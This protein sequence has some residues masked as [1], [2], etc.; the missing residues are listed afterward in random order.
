MEAREW[1]AR[2]SKD[3]EACSLKATRFHYTP[4]AVGENSAN[5][6][7]GIMTVSSSNTHRFNFVARLFAV[8]PGLLMLIVFFLPAPANASAPNK[9]PPSYTSIAA[10]PGGGFWIQIDDGVLHETIAIDGAPQYES[11]PYPGSIAAIPGTN[12]YWVVTTTG[13]IYARG[14]APELCGG[15]LGN[16]SGFDGNTDRITGA[17][18]SPNGDGFWAVDKFR[19]VWTAGNVISYGD[20]TG[21]DQTA[22]GIVATPSGRGY[23]IVMSDGGV[24]CF[25]D[26]VFY[27]ST[28]GQRP[29]G[30]DVTGLSLSYDLRGNVNGYWLVADDGG[31]FSYGDAPFLGST[32]GDDGGSFVTSIVTRPNK[33]SYAWAHANGRV[34][35]STIIPTTKIEST[36]PVG[37]VWGLSDQTDEAGATILRMPANSSTSQE[38]DLWPTSDDGKIVQIIN[39]YSGLCANVT[40]GARGPYLIQYPCKGENEGW[41]NQRFTVTTHTSGCAR[42][43]PT[44]VDFSPVNSPTQRVVT[45]ENERLTLTSV[46]EKFW[47][48]IKPQAV[49]NEQ[50]P[51]QN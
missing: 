21:D 47:T 31:V 39:V 18:A 30:H 32:G 41:D 2:Q 33:R 10:A 36:A 45:G 24:F 11:V 48:L 22:S 35:L 16:C 12:A 20:V 34:G 50:Q 3:D 15:Y 23:Y 8:L 1:I 6:K 44:C 7:R 5:Q 9:V 42:S 51:P 40:S 4:H 49:G 37:G 14:G 28:G 13:F 43:L 19:H 27:G 38:W 29:G 46:G 17:A 26:A 25:G